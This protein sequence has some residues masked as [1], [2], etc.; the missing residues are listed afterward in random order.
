MLLRLRQVTCHP[1]LVQDSLRDLLL[2]EDLQKLKDLCTKPVE[3]HKHDFH[4]I[5][6]LRLMLKQE[7][8]ELPTLDRCPSGELQEVV[9]EGG[10]THAGDDIGN[11]F[12]DPEPK[13]EDPIVASTV[14]AAP[15][16]SAIDP[17]CIDT[18]ELDIG[19]TGEDRMDTT[20]D[21]GPEVYA[22][23]GIFGRRND[24]EAFI[25]DLEATTRAGEV[26]VVIPCSHCK[27]SAREPHRISCGHMYCSECLLR[28]TNVAVEAQA[29]PIC[30]VCKKP[31]HGHET[32]IAVPRPIK[33][34]HSRGSPA[35]DSL[36]QTIARA[37]QRGKQPKIQDIVEKWVDGNGRMVPSAKTLAFIAQVT[38]WLQEDAS[39]KIIVYTQFITMMKILCRICEMEGWEYVTLQG[40][41]NIEQRNKAIHDFGKK[42][43]I[44]IMLA[45]LKTG[46]TGL[47]LTMACRVILMDVWWNVSTPNLL[48]SPPL[49]TSPKTSSYTGDILTL[50]ENSLPLRIRLS[51]EHTVGVYVYSSTFSQTTH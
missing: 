13:S 17:I 8:S 30:V 21:D 9:L 50:L 6:H 19:S 20:A 49:I 1:L 40:T 43:G 35:P 37:L 36:D 25:D 24:Y 28:M 46:G 7:P 12:N 10:S 38:N 39:V 16:A 11:M 14:P 23:R 34:S 15:G 18:A 47:N 45:T 29:R 32:Y 26:E 31:Y 3:P 51:L 42:K 41:H 27:E 22:P 48:S 5:R 44:K 33:P 4:V 2:P